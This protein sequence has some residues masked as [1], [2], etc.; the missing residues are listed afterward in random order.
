MATR[1]RIDAPRRPV[2]WTAP[3]FALAACSWIPHA[4]CHYYRLETGS[5]FRVGSWQFSAAESLVVLLIYALLSSLNLAAIV[6]AGVRR[7]SAALT[8][9][10]HLL[11]GSLHL[12]RLFAPFDFEVFG[13]VWPRG[14]SARE[15]A[16]AVCFGLL[17]LAVARKV[18][19]AS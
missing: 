17:C 6:R 12:Y 1:A 16:V 7:P 10:L 8:G 3:F 5:S 13:Y 14:A 2:R 19:T 4:S 9:A 11:I 18:R 15:A